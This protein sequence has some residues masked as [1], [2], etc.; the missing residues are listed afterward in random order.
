[1]KTIML[2]LT[3]FVNVLNINNNIDIYCDYETLSEESFIYDDYT[4]NDDQQVVEIIYKEEVLYRFNKCLYKVFLIDKE[5]YVFFKTVEYDTIRVLRF[6]KN[7]YTENI[8]NQNFISDFDVIVNNDNFIIVG[9]VE[10]LNVDLFA[11]FI[12]DKNYLK[13]KNAII[14]E[15]NFYDGILKANVLGGILNDSF[16]KIYKDKVYY[17]VGK[18]DQNSGYDFGNGGENGTGYIVCKLDNNLKLMDYLVFDEEVK[19]VFIKENKLFVFCINYLYCFDNV[20]LKLYNS[21]KFASS[22]VFGHIIDENL[23]GI[24]SQSQ[25]KIY[26]YVQ[27]YCLD[28]YEYQF[29]ESVNEVF[30]YNDYIYLQ[31]YDNTYKCLFYDKKYESVVF[32]YD[33]NDL[34]SI[35]KELLCI[36]KNRSFVAVEYEEQFSES[37][38]GIYDISLNYGDVKVSTNMEVEKRINI[39]NGGVYPVGYSLKFSGKAYLNEEEVFNNYCLKD[40]GEYQLK[41]IGKDETDL[42]NF[43]IEKMEITYEDEEH[44]NWDYEINRNQDLNININLEEEYD[45]IKKVYVNGESYNF[46]YDRINKQIIIKINEEE[47]G[48]YKYNVSKIEYLIDDNVY[49]QLVDYSIVV[50]VLNDKISIDSQIYDDDTY[51]ILEQYILSNVE[52]IRFFKFV[53][54]KEEQLVYYVPINSESIFIEN[55]LLGNELVEVYLVYDIGGK[56]YEEEYL[57]SFD[58]NFK[59]SYLGELEIYKYKDEVEKIVFKLNKTKYL[60]SLSVEEEIIYEYKSVDYIKPSLISISLVFIM[61]VLVKVIKRKKQCKNKSINC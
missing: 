50:K 58:Y 27:N 17:V 31:D 40:E 28:S 37:V 21:L 45:D 23:V 26:D 7:K 18:K 35:N 38:F 6:T 9:T 33:N 46:T 4:L 60:K 5:L 36:P 44:N 16:T 12:N 56:Y 10:E 39:K 20:A 57:F 25:V 13:Q 41:L 61:F 34:S 54:N 53:I 59:K 14:M 55:N 42:I 52:E 1:M 3:S 30:I 24:L 32:N 29:S 19:N 11:P 22:C 49:D 15:Y 48:L 51:V 47:S 2:L 8:I 43:S